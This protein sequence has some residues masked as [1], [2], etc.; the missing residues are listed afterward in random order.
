[1]ER[2][3][4]EFELHQNSQVISYSEGGRR[5]SILQGMN[6]A[7]YSMRAILKGNLSEH[8]CLSS[9]QLQKQFGG[10]G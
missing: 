10:R 1:M 8:C 2:E 5:D 7:V 3:E 9:L 6:K 4:G